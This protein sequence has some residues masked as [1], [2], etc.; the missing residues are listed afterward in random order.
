MTKQRFTRRDFMERSAGAAALAI[1]TA[2]TLL[3]PPSLL[4][5]EAP[6]GGDESSASHGMA[7][8]PATRLQKASKEYKLRYEGPRWQLIYGSYRGAEE[9]A[10]NEL[11]RTTQQYVPYVL[12]VRRAGEPLD[13]DAHLILLGTTASNPLLAELEKKGAIIVP[14]KP[15]GYT[16]ACLRSPWNPN[17]KCVVIA[18]A[19]ASGTLYGVTH[20][21]KI[22]AGLTRD[23]P[24]EMRQTLDNLVE[25]NTQESPAIQNR[26]VWSWGYV[27]YDYR[28][29]IDNLARLRMNRLLFWNDVP[30]LNCR[31]IIDYAHSR[32]VKVVLGFAW[33]WGM[34]DLDP[35]SREDRQL[36]KD[37]VLCRVDQF[38]GR[39]GMDAIYFQT[40]T[41]TLQKEIGG[42][43]LAALARDW[44]NDIAGA[45]L[46][47]YP[48]L[49]IEWGLHATSILENYKYLESLDRR[50][51][52][53]WEDAGVIPYAYDPITRHMSKSFPAALDNPEATIEYSRKL[54]TFRANSEFA[55]VAK[56]WTN[57][58]WGTEFEHHGPFIMGERAPDFIRNRLHE[59]QPRWDYV[60]SLWLENY[61]EAL[62][63]YQAILAAS[64]SRMTVLGL[65]EDG[66]L[67]EKIQ[68]GAALF[69]EMLWNPGRSA[70]EILESALN[71]YYTRVS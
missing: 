8:C 31:E 26:G 25:F 45:I 36:V 57:L 39:L 4:A 66:I 37:E 65:I 67:E 71:P 59:R 24:K 54:A 32:G 21:N 41:E 7:E 22:L 9:F 56:G 42:N 34:G 18:G 11:Q 52:I 60:N 58:R 13:S 15:E 28:R 29:F 46:A 33:G 48:D 49:R 53:V 5:R 51:V 2:P 50:I 61:P 17:R 40:F 14:R 16:C 44:V 1:A 64:P 38:Y 12:E 47:R 20:F 43:P 69:A 10:L 3:N 68:L 6:A 55:M 35:N 23:D 62:R 63:F 70:Q 19:D 27:I 30:P